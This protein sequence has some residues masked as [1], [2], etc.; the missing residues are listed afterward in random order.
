[1]YNCERQIRRAVAQFND[2]AVARH[3]AGLLCVDNQS[4]DGTETAAAEALAACPVAGRY[5]LRNDSNYGLGGSHKVAIDFARRHGFDQLAVLHGDDQ[6]HVADLLPHLP[7]MEAE[8]LDALLGARFMSGSRLVGYS[9]LRTAA[10]HVFNWIFSIVAGR[11]LHDLGSGLNCFSLAHFTDDFHKKYRDDLTFNYYLILGLA[12]RRAHFEFFPLT[13]RED[14]Q[15]S[16][17]KLVRQG[18]RMLQLLWLR[19]RDRRQFLEGEHRDTPRTAYPSSQVATW[20]S[21]LPPGTPS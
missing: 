19:L 14:D 11:R 10:N 21:A 15:V 4:T 17:A 1:M 3:F 5:L 20:P 13:W 16:N 8:G 2:P 12:L 6:G 18:L 7:R 9:W